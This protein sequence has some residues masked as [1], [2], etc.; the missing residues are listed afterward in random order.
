[1][2]TYGVPPVAPLPWLI[3]Y[4][5]SSLALLAGFDVRVQQA[6]P[7]MPGDMFSL[8]IQRLASKWVMPD[9][10][11]FHHVVFVGT[12]ALARQVFA[13]DP[14]KIHFGAPNPIGKVTGARSLFSLDEEAHLEQRKI[15]LPPLHG[16]RMQAYEAIVEDETLRELE[17]WADGRERRTTGAFMRITLNI[18]MRAVFGIREGPLMEELRVK[19]PQAVKIGSRLTGMGPFQRDLGPRSPYGRF[20]A[21]IQRFEWGVNALIDQARRDPQLDQRPDVLALL[22]A[23]THEDGSPLSDQEIADQLKAI[24]AAGHETTANTLAWAVE[25]LSRHPRV[26]DRLVQEVD[27]EGKE[28]REATI[29]EI[30]RTRPVIPGTG[31]FVVAPF[32]LGDYVLPAGTIILLPTPFLHNDPETYPDPLRFDP[33]RFLGKRPDPNTWIPF[34]GGMRR[35]PGAAFAHMEL[36]IVL[37][38]LLRELTI[39]PTSARGE[40][41]LFRGIAFAPSGGGRGVFRRRAPAMQAG[42][43][44]APLEVAA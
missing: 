43:S 25:R 14:K 17:R 27:D 7:R 13:G 6:V 28:Y 30:Q 18:I 9:A 41:M 35:C 39:E 24:V 33:E 2:P 19:T 11:P 4:G 38:T 16:Q 26:L 22:A 3:R 42:G 10:R 32:E 34:G 23:A 8:P 20:K 1:M 31:R 40:R 5:G 21:L 12:P 37:R 36:D 15:I 29:R 44:R